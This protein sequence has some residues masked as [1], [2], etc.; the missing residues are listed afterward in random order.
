[1]RIL[2]KLNFSGKHEKIQV[3]AKNDLIYSSSKLFLSSLSVGVFCFSLNAQEV[4]IIYIL[5]DD[6]GYGD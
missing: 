6:L 5:A 3:N 4:N 1:M 2:S